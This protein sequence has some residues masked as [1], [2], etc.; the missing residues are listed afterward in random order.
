MK[1]LADTCV[2]SRL[3]RKT[4]DINDP[5]VLALNELIKEYR[6]QMIGLI[7]QEILSGIRHRKQFNLLRDH[8]RAFSDLDIQTQD[9]ETAAQMSNLCRRK[10]I[11]GSHIDFLICAVA[12]RYDLAIF[13]IDQD[14]HFYKR[15]IPL[16][17]FQIED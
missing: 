12:Q 16:Q 1:V 10:G 6:V 9:Y 15:H 13:T 4:V 11:Q 2:W 8:L 14:F 5:V 17:L 3:L 7:R